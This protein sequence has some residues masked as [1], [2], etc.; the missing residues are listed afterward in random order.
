MSTTR[1]ST[2]TSL[3]SNRVTSL[4]KVAVSSRKFRGNVYYARPYL[5]GTSCTQCPADMS[6]C[7]DNKCSS[8]STST[9]GCECKASCKNGGTVKDDCTCDCPDGYYGSDCSSVCANTNKY[10]GANPGWPKSWC[11]D[12]Y[13]FVLQNCPLMCGKCKA[14]KSK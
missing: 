5:T 4:T 8:C 14:P 11:R 1:S 7:Y 9:T 10:C 13:P 3:R 2:I 12:K 6:R